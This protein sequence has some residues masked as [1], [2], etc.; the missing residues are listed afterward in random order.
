MKVKNLQILLFLLIPL[1]VN[2]QYD[3]SAIRKESFLQNLS[4]QAGYQ[5]GYVFASNDFLRG[6]N[7]E[8]ERINA[9][10]A[11]S[12]KLSIHTTG[13]KIWEQMFKYPSWGIGLSVIDFYNPEEIGVPIALFGF[14]N[15]PFKR[16]NKWSF[17][18][19]IGFGASFNW[20]SFN[21]VKNKY[22]VAIGAG[23]SFLIDAGLNMHYCF[24]NRLEL[25]SGFSLTH[26]SNGAL[27]KPNFGINTVAPKISLKYNF[28]DS[29]D[30]KKQ[31]VPVCSKEREW[32]VSTFVGAKNVIF[33]S[34]QI[35]IYEKYE[36][37]TFP[38]W[39]L[40]T[41]YNRQISYKSKIGVG[42]TFSYDGSINAQV[43]VEEGELDPV[44]SPFHEKLELSI[45]PSYEL[46]IN[47]VSLVIQPAFYLYRKKLKKQSPV[48]H[49]RIG[50]KYY[51]SNNT[52]VGITLRDYAFHVSDFV[53]WTVGFRL[54]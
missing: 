18:Y 48:F 49:Q 13:K 44:D 40:S 46:V 9:F 35:D 34:V 19:E 54:K 52:F 21:P 50:L 20:K 11:F 36:G 33:D 22:N 14:F 47:R 43:A 26:F 7:I 31:E 37:V 15:A 10:Q 28:H 53:E 27:K 32:L 17:N 45:Y 2:G 25:E 5:N 4:L 6:N 3:S 29:P 39:G 38:V 1:A 30:F 51:I 24:T 41:L 23:E 12:F 42:M 8:A 16:W